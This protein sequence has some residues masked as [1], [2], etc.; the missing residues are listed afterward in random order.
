MPAANSEQA[1][2]GFK[3]LLA[4]RDYDTTRLMILPFLHSGMH[5]RRLI[6]LT[7]TKFVFDGY[8]RIEPELLPIER[9][10]CLI[11]RKREY[12]IRIKEMK[13]GADTSS[14]WYDE[15]VG[16]NICLMPTEI[17]ELTIE[18]VNKRLT[19]P[20]FSAVT[21]AITAREESAEFK[22]RNEAARRARADMEYA[23]DVAKFNETFKG[24][25]TAFLKN[26]EK[27]E[28]AEAS[29]NE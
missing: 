25:L 1:A 14:Y 10:I 19:G 3:P 6:T 7:P 27:I 11:G 2:Q 21:D 17:I 4:P 18:I 5:I 24:S 15:D 12:H 13:R 22:E 23:A 8:F 29:T 20:A 28:A 26:N 9:V 16:E